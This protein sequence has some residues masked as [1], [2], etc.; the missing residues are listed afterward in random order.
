[1]SDE[2]DIVVLNS[3]SSSLK[4]GLYRRGGQDEE[5]VMNGSAQGIGRETGSIEIRSAT[6]EQLAAQDHL[7]ESQHAPLPKLSSVL[8][9]HIHVAPTAVGHRIVHGGPHL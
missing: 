5:V 9:Q 7:L 4:F 2:G 6:G 8:K 1:M 3:G